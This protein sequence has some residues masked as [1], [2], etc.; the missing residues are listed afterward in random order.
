MFGYLLL[1]AL[2][3]GGFPSLLRSAR[4]LISGPLVLPFKV[5]VG[6]VDYGL[7]CAAMTIWIAF[8]QIG[9][10]VPWLRKGRP[11][12]SVK[13]LRSQL[14]ASLY[15]QH[16]GW[17][18]IAAIN[19][20]LAV[21]LCLMVWMVRWLR[22]H[23]SPQS[24]WIALAM[25]VIL[26]QGV[27]LGGMW[28]FV[29]MLQSQ[30]VRMAQKYDRP[31]PQP[32]PTRG[33][34]HWSYPILALACAFLLLSQ[35]LIVTCLFGMTWGAYRQCLTTRHLD[36]NW[37]RYVSLF[38]AAGLALV[39]APIADPVRQAIGAAGLLT[40]V[41]LL[42]DLSPPVLP[43]AEFWRLPAK[44][45]KDVRQAHVAWVASTLAGAL[46]AIVGI[47]GWPNDTGMY[48]LLAMVMGS[49]LR[50]ADAWSSAFTVFCL[51]PRWTLWMAAAHHAGWRG[52]AVFLG[53]EVVLLL[54]TIE[55]SWQLWRRRNLRESHSD[56]RRR[57]LR[58]RPGPLA[59]SVA[60][61]Q[62]SVVLARSAPYG[63]VLRRGP[64]DQS[65]LIL[66]HTD[67]DQFED[68]DVFSGYVSPRL[69]DLSP[70]GRR[71]VYFARPHGFA[72]D[73]KFWPGWTVVCRPP[74]SVPL[75]VW[76]KTDESNGGGVF[77]DDGRLRLLH[78]EADAAQGASM[79]V[80]TGDLCGNGEI[81]SE[82]LRQHGWVLRPEY[83]ESANYLSLRQKHDQ[84]SAYLL[85]EC[86]AGLEICTAADHSDPRRLDADW[87]DWEQ[88]NRLVAVRG[89]KLYAGEIGKDGE[90]T[91]RELADFTKA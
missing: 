14:Y 42:L 5:G 20:A 65:R 39:T 83:E 26:A 72:R 17:P 33:L 89:M 32:I 19:G 21:V 44:E 4:S 91:W 24:N 22:P 2:W 16:L 90:V 11:R 49:A 38:A 6:T 51:V 52:A 23:S 70:D 35:G 84:T 60:S 54:P 77:L 68:G 28:A 57:S 61:C 45:P 79:D 63:V 73:G 50:G 31:E 47:I 56:A 80:Q 78:A 12:Q 8:Q 85:R 41:L 15:L 86:F 34:F 3:S 27:V 43:L 88:Q 67:T 13:R 75:T 82:R 59:Q 87:A 64:K 9:V 29:R 7:L 30:T 69:C 53:C 76:K 74:N 58:V 71:F 40:A 10:G 36:W 25:L 46:I 66:W 48:L 37:A 18:M 55:A 1:V 81:H 62:I